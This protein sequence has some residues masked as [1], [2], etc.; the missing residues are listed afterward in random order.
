[1]LTIARTVAAV[2]MAVVLQLWV[3]RVKR[4][5]SERGCARNGEGGGTCKRV[6]QHSTKAGFTCG[7]GAAAHC[8]GEHPRLGTRP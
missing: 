5:N 7:D 3:G 4:K 6:S 8:N 1:V 2:R